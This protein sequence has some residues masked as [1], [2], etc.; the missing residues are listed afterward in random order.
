MLKHH[1]LA[2]LK[3]WINTITKAEPPPPKSHNHLPTWSKLFISRGIYLPFTLPQDSAIAKNNLFDGFMG[4][5]ATFNN[6]SAISW[7]SVLLVEE[8]GVSGE[9]L[10]PAASHRQTLSHNVVSPEW[11]SNSQP[12]VVIGTDC[13]CSGKSNY[14]MITTMTA[15]NLFELDMQNPYTCHISRDLIQT[16]KK[17]IC[18]PENLSQL[19]KINYL[20]FWSQVTQTPFQTQIWAGVPLIFSLFR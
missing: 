6:N 20:T 8:T 7:R 1:S 12:L 19:K 3:S 13:I 11:D 5:N 16:N 9:N 10:W 15:F 4:L 14:H 2:G 18:S 17:F